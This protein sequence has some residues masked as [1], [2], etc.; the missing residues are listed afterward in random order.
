[1]AR[2]VSA[3]SLAPECQAI[4]YPCNEDG[5]SYRDPEARIPLAREIEETPHLY[6]I[7]QSGYQ[8]A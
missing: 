8:Q 3:L 4:T 1:M 6:R 7:E 2:G 5:S